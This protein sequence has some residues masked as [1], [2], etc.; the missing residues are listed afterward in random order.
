[1]LSNIHEIQEEPEDSL[2]DDVRKASKIDPEYQLLYET[3]TKGFPNDNNIPTSLRQYL[4]KKDML[5]IDQGL[6]VCGQ[7]LLIPKS[8]R[9]EILKRLHSSHQGIEKT[10]RRARQCAY[11][12]GIN[13]DV[14][15]VVKSC[16]QCHAKFYCQVNK[17]KL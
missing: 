16:K 8:M 1:M 13:N 14:E 9:K 15:N 10:R 4:N 17:K 3:I 7:R 5:C 12:P 2:L 6:V 11:W